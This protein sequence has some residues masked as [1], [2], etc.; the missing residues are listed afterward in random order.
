VAQK[1]TSII[2]SRNNQN[3]LYGYS[4]LSCVSVELMSCDVLKYI[5]YMYVISDV[6]DFEAVDLTRLTQDR[7]D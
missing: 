3:V 2:I 4:M 5:V 6:T 7:K 1:Q